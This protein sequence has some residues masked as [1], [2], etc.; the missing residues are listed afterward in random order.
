MDRR[1]KPGND[2]P[3]TR[4]EIASVAASALGLDP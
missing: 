3:K 4:S 2:E 1:V